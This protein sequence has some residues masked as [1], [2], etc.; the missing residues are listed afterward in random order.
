MKGKEKKTI[1]ER[2]KGNQIGDEGATS[3]SEG[4]KVNTTLTSLN[5]QSKKSEEIG[6]QKR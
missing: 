4:L 2:I 3:L 1:K 6:K 5:L